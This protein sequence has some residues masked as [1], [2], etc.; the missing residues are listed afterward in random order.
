MIAVSY[1]VTQDVAAARRRLTA[2]GYE[3]N[4]V[5]DVARTAIAAREAS[6]PALSALSDG[7]DAASAEIVA[8]LPT[9]TPT[10]TPTTAP[11]PPPLPTT[12]LTATSTAPPAT[13]T[14]TLTPMPTA[15]APAATSTPQ[16][17][18]ATTT[19]TPAIDFVV[20][21]RRMLTKEENPGA[22][23]CGLNVLFLR[24][25]DAAG[26]P[27]DGVRLRVRWETGSEEIVSGSKAEQPGNAEFVLAG[28]YRVAVVGD[29]GGRTYTSEVARRIDSYYPD[30]ADLIAAGYCQDEVECREREE[31]N[32]LCYG[33]Y[34]WI[35]E[36]RR[37]W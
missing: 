7:L 1:L 11:T 36:F 26:T 13:A 16:P 6:A 24:V 21:E 37:T 4:A 8:W 19:P 23:G 3:S 30:Y 34:S 33:H 18:T 14:A 17:P 15:P 35:V 25:R 20:A 22:D 28:A 27:L 12:T 31:N 5:A 32:Q 9:P 2:L 29:A 10:A